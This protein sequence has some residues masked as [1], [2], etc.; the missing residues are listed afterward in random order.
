MSANCEYFCITSS[1]CLEREVQSLV[2]T[3]TAQ[4]SI[5]PK[6][7]Y[8]ISK[9]PTGCIARTDTTYHS[10]TPIFPYPASSYLVNELTAKS[11]C[12]Y[13]P[14]YREFLC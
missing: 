13:F 7:V 12:L 1:L 14:C 4:L 8:Y 3:T 11:E 9:Q 2:A 10:E 6:S 5:P